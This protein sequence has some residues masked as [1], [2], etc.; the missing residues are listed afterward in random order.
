LPSPRSREGPQSRLDSTR[1]TILLVSEGS[2]ASVLADIAMQLR[3]RYNVVAL[4]ASDGDPVAGFENFCAD[5]IGP[6]AERNYA[7]AEHAVKQLL[8]SMPI[9][10]AIAPGTGTGTAIR[11][12]TNAFVP[13][14]TL[15][16]EFGSDP[17]SVGARLDTL[18]W[19]T[20]V[21]FSDQATAAAAAREHPT[22]R[23]RKVHVLPPVTTGPTDAAA[24]TQDVAHMDQ[25]VLCID[26]LGREAVEIMRQRAQD[27]VTLRDDPL[28][29]AD[30]F[31]APNSAIS[32]R[33]A[34]IIAFLTRWAAS[35]HSRLPGTNFFLRRP[36]TGFHPQ[37]YAYENAGRYDTATINPLAHLIRSRVP[38]GPWRHE[39]I[40]PRVHVRLSPP[41]AELRTA[42]HGHFFYPELAADFLQSLACN[43]T[44]CDVWL[45]TDDEAKAAML[46]EAARGYERGDVAVRVVPN[47]GRDIGAFLTGVVADIEAEHDVV[48][49]IHGKRSPQ[50]LVGDQW[51]NFLWQ[52]LVGP[53]HPMMDV[54]LDRFAADQTL[55]IVFP[56][57]PHLPDW[58]TNR[59][60]ASRLAARMGI[61]GPL[62]PYFNFP[63]GT[64]FWARSAALTP[65]TEL[66]LG[67]QDYPEEPVAADGTILHAL[68]RLLPFVAQ[69]AGYRYATTHVPAVNWNGG[70]GTNYDLGCDRGIRP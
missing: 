10:Y 28:F 41:A 65:L 54:I 51:R 53:A 31:L 16:S 34:A 23:G 4:L 14:V 47:R 1:A 58:D 24:A 56:D 67:W 5:V 12:L 20:C 59:D 30:V 62:P 26:Q 70:L 35:G 18:D 64:A 50:T 45:T 63:V 57:D 68:E 66:K 19:S 22:L 11:A 32:T 36:C 40:T 27:F 38:D 15:V 69:R 8:A 43:R 9:E 55:G 6:L 13:V 7:A 17:R 29:D 48:G 46:R 33:E 37:I 42:I 49:H 3:R 39:V 61:K 21:I 44:S 60:V 25:H 52:N 2:G